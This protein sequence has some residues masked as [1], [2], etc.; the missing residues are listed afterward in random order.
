M[1]SKRFYRIQEVSEMLDIPASTLRYWELE[2]PMFNPNRTKGGQRRFTRADIN[3]AKHIKTLMH[4]KGLSIDAAVQVMNKTYRSSH[5]SYQRLCRTP[6]EALVLLDEVKAITDNVY[7][8]AK[9]KSIE[10][11]IK[12]LDKLR[13]HENIRGKEYFAKAIKEYDQKG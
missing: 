7:A 2:F 8:L 9:I 13:L 12:S 3:K 6:Q 1:P 4:E 11:W 5:S 10:G